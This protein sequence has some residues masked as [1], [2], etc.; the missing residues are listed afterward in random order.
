MAS[1]TFLLFRPSLWLTI[2][3][4]L[5]LGF[6]AAML[7]IQIPNWLYDLGPAKPLAIDSPEA[8]E[9]FQP[10]R[11][12]F[13]SVKGEPDFERAFSYARYG[14]TYTYFNIRPFGMGIV[15]RTHRSVDE[16]WKELNRFLGRLRPF[17]HQP[18]SYRI[19]AIYRDKFQTEVPERAYFLALD[20]VPRMTG[21]KIGASAFALVLWMVMF[22]FFFLWGRRRRRAE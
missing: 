7:A 1:K 4:L 16:D 12:T 13:V 10:R 9:R 19:R 5:F 18:F 8:L 17:G 14:L 22:Y 3:K 6:V 20:E 15:V 21:W 11:S 2:L